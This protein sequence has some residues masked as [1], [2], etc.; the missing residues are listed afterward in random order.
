MLKLSLKI[1]MLVER[2]FWFHFKEGTISKHLDVLSR[3]N[4]QM[5]VVIPLAQNVELWKFYIGMLCRP[6]QRY[7]NV[8]LWREIQN[9]HASNDRGLTGSS[10]LIWV[11][12]LIT[13]ALFKGYILKVT[14]ML[15]LCMKMSTLC[16]HKLYI[17]FISC[18]LKNIVRDTNGT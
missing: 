8:C 10:I 15:K 11:M 4:R 9:F 18:H 1:C 14:L 12:L 5:P 3:P 16:N 7:C 2:M 13:T 17:S 6:T